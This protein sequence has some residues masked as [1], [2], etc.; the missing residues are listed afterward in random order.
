VARGKTPKEASLAEMDALWDEA[1][2]AE[3]S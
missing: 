3:N 1:K 2:A